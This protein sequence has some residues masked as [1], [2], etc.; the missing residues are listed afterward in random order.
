[1]STTTERNANRPGQP[2]PPHSF[3][4][5]VVG[6]LVAVV[7]LG[8]GGFLWLTGST[9]GPTVGGPF[10]LENG[11]GTTVTDKDF[12]G[13]YMLVYFGYTYCPDVC[14]TTLNA[15][16]DAIDKLGPKAKN[17]QPIFITVDPQRDTPAV[18]KQYTAAFSPALLGLTGTPDEIAAAAKE[19]RVYY[20]KHQT[21]PGPDD[22]SMD[23][24]SV[25][26]LMGPDGRF[27]APIRA[28][29]SGDELA[30]AISKLMS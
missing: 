29:E 19:Y 6:L 13:K 28:D 21:G 20:A 15:V 9:G 4:F 7:L 17:L 23:H 3:L 1:M 2:R 8:T 27:I 26:Y 18:I 14:P 5:A 22:Y 11:S 16:A 24:S 25:I 10:T 30:A 12:R